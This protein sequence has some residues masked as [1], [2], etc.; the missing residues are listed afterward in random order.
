MNDIITLSLII[1][2]TIA[3][4]EGENP[5]DFIL[6]PLQSLIKTIMDGLSYIGSSIFAGIGNTWNAMIDAWNK[7]FTSIPPEWRI[8]LPVIV[9]VVVIVFVLV[10]YVGY[11]G[12]KEV[13]NWLEE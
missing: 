6:Q 8:F 9:A 13:G 4:A 2:S 10:L 11:K 3:L 7:S 5:L 1:F 12:V